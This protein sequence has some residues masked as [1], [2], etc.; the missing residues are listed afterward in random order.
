MPESVETQ[1]II[2]WKALGLR[3]EGWMSLSSQLLR[4]VGP[5]G[6]LQWD[7]G[8]SWCCLLNGRIT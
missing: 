7:V 3:I 6:A 1:H 5:R 8:F 2:P 4:I